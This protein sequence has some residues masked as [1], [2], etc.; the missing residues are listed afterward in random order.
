MHYLKSNYNSIATIVFILI[1]VLAHLLM[2][3]GYNIIK[4]TISDLGAQG[5]ERKLIMQIGFLAFGIILSV[6]VFLNGI[7]WRTTPILVYAIC[8]AMTG[9]FC[10]KPFF[11]AYT[12][13]ESQAQIHS[14]FAQI[15]GVFF[16]LGILAQIFYSQTN[17]EKWL[18]FLFLVLVILFSASF[19]FFKSYQGIC[20]RLLYLSSFIWL[21]KFYKP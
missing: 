3:S 21:I 20:Q 10:T 15:A 18:H 11:S 9:I 17:N 16:T 2:T 13:S 6:G 12:Y 4:N 5:Y 19:A 8:V 14:L 1:I 7:S